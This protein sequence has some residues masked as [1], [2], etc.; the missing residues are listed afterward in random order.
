MKKN[1]SAWF[2]IILLFGMLV[3]SCAVEDLTS[4]NQD[5]SAG[6]SG[7]QKDADGKVHYEPTWESLSKKDAAPQWFEDAVLGIYFHWGIYSVPGNGCWTGMNMYKKSGVE[8]Q[9]LPEGY[10]STYEY[11]KE[12]YGEPGTEWGYKDFVPMFTAEKVGSEALGCLVQACG[13][14]LRWAGCGSP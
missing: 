14:G 13:C 4:G 8:W 9:H 6:K 7:I 3:S 2:L 5:K 12:T 10:E 11:I 1:I